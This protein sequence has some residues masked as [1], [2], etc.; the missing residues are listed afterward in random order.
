MKHL[1]GIDHMFWALETETTTGVMGG[2]IRFDADA[3]R[4]RPDA[5]FMRA[6]IG[7]GW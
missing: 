1:N 3:D 5:A 4:D 7:S 2:L 6:R